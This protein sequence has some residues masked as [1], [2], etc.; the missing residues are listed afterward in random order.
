MDIQT[1]WYDNRLLIV[2]FNILTYIK[3]CLNHSDVLLKTLYL[4]N[5]GIKLKK[6][7]KQISRKIILF[8]MNIQTYGMIIELLLILIVLVKVQTKISFQKMLKIL[9][10]I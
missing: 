5:L 10:S 6:Q 1:F 9:D 2:S 4:I 8:E 3:T 7:N